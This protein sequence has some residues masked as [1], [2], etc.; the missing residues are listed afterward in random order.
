MRFFIRNL[1]KWNTTKSQVK[2]NKYA[3]YTQDKE[4]MSCIFVRNPNK[5]RLKDLNGFLIDCASPHGK[6]EKKK[7]G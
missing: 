4:A 1:K 7:I 5:K 2:E 6:K 3:L